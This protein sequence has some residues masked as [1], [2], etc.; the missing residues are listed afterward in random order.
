MIQG[1]RKKKQNKTLLFLSLAWCTLRRRLLPHLQILS[2]ALRVGQGKAPARAE[3]T[4]AGWTGLDSRHRSFAVRIV[5]VCR[6][7]CLTFSYKTCRFHGG[8]HRTSYLRDPL[9]SWSHSW[10][11]DP[12]YKAHNSLPLTVPFPC[13]FPLSMSPSFHR[14][15]L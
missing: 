6:L 1:Y 7:H 10:E 12:A 2:G 3:G 9:G 13:P 5:C 14:T 8:D 4:S 11:V 15:W